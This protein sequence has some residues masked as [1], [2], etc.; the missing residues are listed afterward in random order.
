[1]AKE[2]YKLIPHD[3]KDI[4]SFKILLGQTELEKFFLSLDDKSPKTNNHGL[5][6]LFKSTIRQFSTVDDIE[7]IYYYHQYLSKQLTKKIKNYQHKSAAFKS[8]IQY[9]IEYSGRAKN[10]HVDVSILESIQGILDLLIGY[11]DEK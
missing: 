7:L 3:D 11:S 4:L 8:T 2:K 9:L 1:M 6:T 5:G 10:H